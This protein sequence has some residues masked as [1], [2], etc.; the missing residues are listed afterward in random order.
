MKDI[1]ESKV[2]VKEGIDNENEDDLKDLKKTSSELQKESILTVTSPSTKFPAASSAVRVR[3]QKGRGRFVVAAQ[4]IPVGTTLVVEQPVTWA[5]HP[6]RFGSH[7]QHCLGQVK[8][9]LPCP[10]CCG[11]S[12]C[13]LPCRGAALASYHGV[14][15]GLNDVLS[16]SGLNIYPS[17]TIRLMTK[18]GL[19]HIWE[20]REKLSSHNDQA[21]A[22]EEIEKYNS[23]DFQKAFNLVCH[24]DKMDEEDHLLRTFVSIFLFKLLKFNNF[25]G[26]AAYE[27]TREDELSEK[28]LFIATIILHFTNT[29]PQNVHDIA[30]LQTPE[31]KRWV[32]AAQIKSL[33]AGVFL[34]SALFNHSCDPSFMRC[35]FGKGMVSV[36]NRHIRA[37][38][39]I[40]ECYGQMYYSKGREHRRTELERHYKF[41][42]CCLACLEDWPT[43]KDLQYATGGSETKHQ[44]RAEI[45]P[46]SV[47]TP[48]HPV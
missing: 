36:A 19:D 25:F 40:S 41:E 12:F 43:I 29:F 3:Y 24:E 14:E 46:N 48:H 10:S 28:E 34:T 20:L 15:C 21:G 7:C 35:N 30:L 26:N 11:V 23:D 13:S 42:C 22:T 18:F 8:A 5:L 9:V 47:S 4:D 38:E 32:N 2:K 37:G 33:G 27:E 6:D 45:I 16:A 17:L 31:S 44:V 39:E 1:E